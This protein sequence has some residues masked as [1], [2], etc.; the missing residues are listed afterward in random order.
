[1]QSNKLKKERVKFSSVIEMA[2]HYETLRKVAY[3]MTK[4]TL[5]LSVKINGID[6]LTAKKA[7]QWKNIQGESLRE[8][9]SSWSWEKAYESSKNLPDRFEISI[10]SGAQLCAVTYGRP[11]HH[12]TK[13]KLMLVESSPIKPSPLTCKTFS[14]ISTCA[15]IYADL[16]DADEVYIID[17]VN[18]AVASY[19]MQFGYSAPL[20]YLGKRIYMRKSVNV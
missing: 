17:P 12:R 4:E 6:L 5:G 11:S 16:I 13:L 19:Y 8:Q 20:P 14:I 18:D 7:D 9:R 1:M 2:K 10:W 3:D 15:M